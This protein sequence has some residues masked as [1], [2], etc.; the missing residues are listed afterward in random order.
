VCQDSRAHRACPVGDAYDEIKEHESI[1]YRSLKR[2]QRSKSH[3]GKYTR[4]DM[5]ETI[6]MIAQDDFEIA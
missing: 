3:S 6:A 2:D 4:N 1:Q 5:N